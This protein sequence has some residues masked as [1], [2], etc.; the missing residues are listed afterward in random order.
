MTTR[1]L[2]VGSATLIASD[3]ELKRLE[4]RL[5][6]WLLRALSAHQMYRQTVR[7]QVTGPIAA[8]F[9]LHDKLFPRAVL[10]TTGEIRS[11]LKV[12][13][14]NSGAL[15]AL[16]RAERRVRETDIHTVFPG[17]FHDLID[18]IQQDLGDIHDSIHRTWFAPRIK[19]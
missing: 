14:R 6:T 19:G 18:E 13:P 16:G 2:D 8:G 9:L 11:C 15:R 4:N 7:R 10:H 3:T 1:I 17:A 12:L 5:W